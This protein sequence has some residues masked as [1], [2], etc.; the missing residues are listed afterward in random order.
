MALAA[1]HPRLAR[2]W[3]LPERQTPPIARQNRT[4][5]D[6]LS[7]SRLGSRKGVAVLQVA[8]WETPVAS[9]ARPR[10][11]GAGRHS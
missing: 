3:L 9:C 8:W 1:P 11:G 2:C 4:V 10:S 5:G 6:R 7:G